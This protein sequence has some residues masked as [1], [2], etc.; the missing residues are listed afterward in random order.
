MA[1]HVLGDRSSPG[2]RCSALCWLLS[3]VIIRRSRRRI[4]LIV[5]V[6]L[7]EFIQPRNSQLHI[8][9]YSSSLIR[10]WAH[11][12]MMFLSTLSLCS[13]PFFSKAAAVRVAVPHLD[14]Y[15]HTRNCHGCSYQMQVC[16][17]FSRYYAIKTKLVLL[18]FEIGQHFS[19]ISF[20]CHVLK[21]LER[22]AAWRYG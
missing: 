10:R 4:V 13:W 14:K 3:Y 12:R 2:T 6:C 7:Y 18:L 15:Q 8:D 5:I 21:F 19:F 20:H 16:S 1:P 22:V 9:K 11:T 17:I